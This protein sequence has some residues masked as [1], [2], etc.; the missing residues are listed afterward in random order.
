M[1]HSSDSLQYFGS[2]RA[3]ILKERSLNSS[4]EPR[5]ISLFN[6]VAVPEIVDV[7]YINVIKIGVVI[8]NAIQADKFRQNMHKTH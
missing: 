7:N 2:S 3:V 4:A 1:F 6:P 8:M 5:Q